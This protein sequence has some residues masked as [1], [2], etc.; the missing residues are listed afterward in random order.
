MQENKTIMAKSHLVTIDNRKKITITNV[1]K[2]ISANENSVMLQLQNNKCV[3]LG[4]DLHI[5]KLDVND[6]VAE[7]VGEVQQFKYLGASTEPKNF[8]K[9]VFQ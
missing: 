7:V 8:L 1:T 3:V 4:K 5:H 2:A 6:G 9:R